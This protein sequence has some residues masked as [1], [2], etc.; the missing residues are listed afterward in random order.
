MYIAGAGQPD[1]VPR[2]ELVRGQ[3]VRQGLPAHVRRVVPGVRVRG[4]NYK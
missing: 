4:T 3:G 1:E 2:G